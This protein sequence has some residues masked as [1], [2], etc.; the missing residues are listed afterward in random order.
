MTEPSVYTGSARQASPLT[1]IE[2]YFFNAKI[3]KAAKKTNPRIN[4]E[5]IGNQQAR[6]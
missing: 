2:I 3:A 1:R 6:S 5:Q 4:T